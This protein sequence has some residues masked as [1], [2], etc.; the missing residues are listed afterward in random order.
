MIDILSSKLNVPIY[1]ITELEREPRNAE[2][3]PAKVI[4]WLAPIASIGGF[5]LLQA[6]IVAAVQGP[7]QG[8]LLLITLIGEVGLIWILNAI[9]KAA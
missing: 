2:S 3:L 4:S 8:L 1:A 5:F 6:R 7:M 9:L